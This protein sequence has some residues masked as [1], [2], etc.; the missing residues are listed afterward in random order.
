MELRKDRYNFK[1]VTEKEKRK[2]DEIGIFEVTR[3]HS[4]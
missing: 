1:A 3:K 4:N 2:D